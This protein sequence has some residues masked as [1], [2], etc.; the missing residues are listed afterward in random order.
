MKIADKVDDL[1]TLQAERQLIGIYRNG[2]NQMR[3]VLSQLYE[4]HGSELTYAEILKYDRL[5]KAELEIANKLKEMNKEANKIITDAI[6][7]SYQE[8]YFFYS[9]SVAKSVNFDFTISM[10][11]VN[12]IRAALL[13][14]YDR[15]S[16]PRRL[17]NNTNQLNDQIRQSIVDGLLRGEGV[18]KVARK[19]KKETWFQ[20]ALIGSKE[21]FN[22]AAVKSKTIVW[23]ETHRAAETGRAQSWHEAKKAADKLKI[24]MEKQWLATLDTKTRDSHQQ[25]DG[26][27]SKEG[28]FDVNGVLAE[29]P[30][31]TG[32]A[33]EDINCRCKAIA[34]FPE[35]PPEYRLDNETKEIREWTNYT[36]WAEEKGYKVK[37]NYN[38]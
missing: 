36:E 14:P 5:G 20:R 37:R 31:N 26:Q 6:K 21:K 7:E 22:Q 9:Y 11:S 29:S 33:E 30:G 28:M 4:K 1:A 24:E 16:W 12:D 2:L 18:E 32:I 27:V 8:N 23:T 10:L 38:A 3:L 15:I 34:Y 19:L 17:A 25:M 35:F 13:N